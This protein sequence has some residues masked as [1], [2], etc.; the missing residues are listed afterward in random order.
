VSFRST[1]AWVNPQAISDTSTTKKVP[2]GTVV[3]AEDKDSTALGVGEFI[4]ALGVA[5]TAVGSVCTI[6]E[7][8]VTALATEDAKGRIGVAM[9]ANVASQYGW[10]QISGKGHALVLTGFADNGVCYLTSTAGSVD[11]TDVAGDLVEGMMGRS[12]IS[13]GMAYVELNRPYVDDTAD[14]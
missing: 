3:R 7:A 11:D 4:Y 14:D 2:V 9:S 1:E 5:S 6:D 8:G 13:G 10:Y 12:A